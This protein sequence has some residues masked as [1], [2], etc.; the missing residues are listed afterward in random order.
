MRHIKVKRLVIEFDDFD[1]IVQDLLSYQ[2]SSIER[3]MHLVIEDLNS[4]IDQCVMLVLYDAG[5][6]RRKLDIKMESITHLLGHM[7]DMYTEF[8]R[9]RPSSQTIQDMRKFAGGLI[10]KFFNKI[11]RTSLWMESNYHIDDQRAPRHRYTTLT[12]VLNMVATRSVPVD[13][14]P[15]L[16]RLVIKILETMYNDVNTSRSREATRRPGQ[17]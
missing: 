5:D 4:I 17:Y 6:P 16:R 1:E 3:V 8:S 14:E 11:C 2:V 12:I 10:L 15:K 7:I 13:L 9:E